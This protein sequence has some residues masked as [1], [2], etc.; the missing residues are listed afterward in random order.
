[1]RKI[2]DGVNDVLGEGRGCIAS[3][4]RVM[5]ASICIG[6]KLLRQTHAAPS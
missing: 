6:V 4:T 1:M 5:K 3:G 2:Q